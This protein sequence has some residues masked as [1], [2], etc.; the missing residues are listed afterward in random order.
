MRVE[1]VTKKQ[2]SWKIKVRLYYCGMRSINLLADMTNYI[3]L[4]LGQPMHAFDEKIV[5][6]VNVRTLKEDSEFVTLDSQKRKLDKGTLM[7]CH[8]DEPVG[9]AGVMGGPCK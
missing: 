4:E 8:E 1:N 9:I 5:N 7:I 6:S 3:M 2:A